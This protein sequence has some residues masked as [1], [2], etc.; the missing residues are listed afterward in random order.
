[1][2]KRKERET[3]EKRDR[4]G[5]KQRRERIECSSLNSMW[6]VNILLLHICNAAFCM[7]SVMCSLTLWLRKQESA[8]N[9]HIHKLISAE[10]KAD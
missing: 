1:M 6:N 5:E 9:M 4:D 3:E 10:S 7:V 8:F 2:L